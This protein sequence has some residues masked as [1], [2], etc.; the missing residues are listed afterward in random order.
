MELIGITKF[1]GRYFDSSVPGTNIN[2][3]PNE[4]VK[5]VNGFGTDR[6]TL[7]DGGPP[8]IKYLWVSAERF[9]PDQRPLAGIT[10]ITDENK[11]LLVSGYEARQEN[12][13]PVL[14][15]W[16]EGLEA[17][18]AKWLQLVLYSRQQLAE[19]AASS[20]TN[21]TVDEE[22]GIVAINAELSRDG[23]PISPATMLRNA[24]GKEYGGN[25]EPLDAEGYKKSVAFFARYA[26]VK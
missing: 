21:D 14:G 10:E 25:G 9:A 2:T 17:P 22:W 8:F 19:E 5:I 7:E 11:H 23:T 1:A 18:E 20:G 6:G 13:L 3:T 15:R 24:L 4:F 12:E 26:I 16:F